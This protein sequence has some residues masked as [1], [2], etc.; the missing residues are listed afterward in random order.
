MGGRKKKKKSILPAYLIA[1]RTKISNF[2]TNCE[3]EVVWLFT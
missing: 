2:Y 1:A 3:K